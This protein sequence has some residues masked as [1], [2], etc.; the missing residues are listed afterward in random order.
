MS[1]LRFILILL[2][3]NLAFL[4]SMVRLFGLSIEP[5][6]VGEFL[7]ARAIPTIL[8]LFYCT[9]TLLLSLGEKK[10]DTKTRV[11]VQGDRQ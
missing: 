11:V 9:I 2:A 6:H 1:D 10:T 8:A 7:L 3:C 5:N 4:V